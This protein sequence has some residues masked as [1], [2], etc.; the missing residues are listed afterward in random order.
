M[1]G[2]MGGRRDG[3]C[4][5]GRMGAGRMVVGGRMNTFYVLDS[6]ADL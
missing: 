5:G 6:T 2:R 4:V 1:S 3:W